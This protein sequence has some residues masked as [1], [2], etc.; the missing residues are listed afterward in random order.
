LD[1][2]ATTLSISLQYGVP[3]KD[4]VRKLMFSRFEPSG[5]TGDQNIPVATSIIDYIVRFLALN[6]LSSEDL[7]DLGLSGKNAIGLNENDDAQNYD[8]SA[9]APT[10]RACGSFMLRKGTCYLCLNC[11]TSDGSCG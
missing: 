9:S 7:K 4:F 1:A 10:C 11:G 6:Y 2:W 5:F 8:F 3:L